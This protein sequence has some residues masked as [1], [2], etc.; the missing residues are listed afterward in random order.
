MGNDDVVGVV[1]LVVNLTGV[2]HRGTMV[3]RNVCRVLMQ[4]LWDR[5]RYLLGT[6][7]YLIKPIKRHSLDRLGPL[8]KQIVAAEKHLIRWV[9]WRLHE[10]VARYALALEL[11]VFSG[12]RNVLN[13]LITCQTPIANLISLCQ[14]WLLGIG[15]LTVTYI[16]HKRIVFIDLVLEILCCLELRGY[17]VDYQVLNKFLLT[18]RLIPVVDWRLNLSISLWLGCHLLLHRINLWGRMLHAAV[19]SMRSNRLIFRN[20]LDSPKVRTFLRKV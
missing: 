5:M 1:D 11:L 19:A 8:I 18:R 6:I 9:P 13:G 16:F 17:L 20:E 15:G 4:G 7:R 2:Q 3:N 10:I 12:C 14:N